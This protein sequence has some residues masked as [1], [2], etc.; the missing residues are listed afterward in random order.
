M[1]KINIVAVVCPTYYSPEGDEASA[2]NFVSID[3]S[4]T[5]ATGSDAINK[6]LPAS[7]DERKNCDVTLTLLRP[8]NELIDK[9]SRMLTSAGASLDR[10]TSLKDKFYEKDETL[11]REAY[12]Q[13]ESGET[14]SSTQKALGMGKLSVQTVRTSQLVER[15]ELSTIIE[16]VSMMYNDSTSSFRTCSMIDPKTEQK[17]TIEDAL[18]EYHQTWLGKNKHIN[19]WWEIWSTYH[20][21]IQNLAIARLNSRQCDN[22]MLLAH[23]W[24]ENP[25]TVQEFFREAKKYTEFFNIQDENLPEQGQDTADDALKYIGN[26]LFKRER[27]EEILDEENH[28]VRLLD[29]QVSTEKEHKTTKAS[30]DFVKTLQ[31]LRQSHSHNPETKKSLAQTIV[32]KLEST[33]RTLESKQIKAQLEQLSKKLTQSGSDDKSKQ[34]K[35][36]GT[37][38]EKTK[39]KKKSPPKAWSKIKNAVKRAVEEQNPD[40]LTPPLEHILQS[41]SDLQNLFLNLVKTT[42]QGGIP[43]YVSHTLSLYANKCVSDFSKAAKKLI[44]TSS[45]SKFFIPGYAQAIEIVLEDRE[46]DEKL[47]ALV[48]QKQLVNFSVKEL[49]SLFDRTSAAPKVLNREKQTLQSSREGQDIQAACATATNS[50]SDYVRSFRSFFGGGA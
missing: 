34:N 15:P 17:A 13:F 35:A 2:Q 45:T 31:T 33:V 27:E 43:A 26:F 42:R 21:L 4:K 29:V 38:P 1:K 7:P 3:F 24:S 46:T 9:I 14:I 44:Q 40:K 48:L 6:S 25:W 22:K 36:M 20:L 28:Q 8:D 30:T 47:S 10:L 32:Q 16:K 41:N 37:Q 19:I 50:L 5:L 11:W 18:K 23:D 39:L 49:D 12:D